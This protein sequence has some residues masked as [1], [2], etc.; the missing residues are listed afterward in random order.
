MIGTLK[1]T[2]W[3]GYDPSASHYM[4]EIYYHRYAGLSCLKLERLIDQTWVDA[5]KHDKDTFQTVIDLGIEETTERF[6]SKQEVIDHAIGKFK[7]L[8]PD[9]VLLRE[10]ETGVLGEPL[11][12]PNDVFDQ[13]S[14]RYTN[15]LTLQLANDDGSLDSQVE[16]LR[17]AYRAMLDKFVPEKG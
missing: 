9:G 16:L 13:L 12:A 7:E 3:I 4:G 6:L 8:Y 15:Y 17:N 5:L 1:I 11:Y 14:V 10:L 2:S